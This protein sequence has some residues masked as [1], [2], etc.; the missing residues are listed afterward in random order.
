MAGEPILTGITALV[1]ASIALLIVFGV[2][3]TGEQRDAIIAFIA[4]LYAVALIVR[5]QV[6]PMVKDYAT[7]R[8]P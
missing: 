3:V 6:R 4:A 7:T 2:H 8:R 1:G 5:S